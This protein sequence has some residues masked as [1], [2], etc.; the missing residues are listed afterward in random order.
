M[1]ECVK[2]GIGCSCISDP[3]MEEEICLCSDEYIARDGMCQSKACYDSLTDSFCSNYPGASCDN[4]N[5]KCMCNIDY[6]VSLNGRC[7]ADNCITEDPDTN[8]K[9]ECWGRGYCM[10]DYGG[11]NCVC[12]AAYVNRILCRFCNPDVAIE[13][14]TTGFL[15]ECVP[16]VCLDPK[17]PDVNIICNGYGT[18]EPHLQS[19][20]S[21]TYSCVCTEDS[22]SINNS[23]YPLECVSMALS[24]IGQYSVCNGYGTCNTATKACICNHPYTG[25]FCRSCLPG[26]ES[27]YTIT[28][29][30]IS[31]NCLPRTCFD[32]LTNSFCAGY[33]SCVLDSSTQTYKC[34]CNKDATF[35]SSFSMLCVPTQLLRQGVKRKL[36]LGLVILSILL[37]IAILGI[38]LYFL[39]KFLISKRKDK[40]RITYIKERKTEIARNLHKEAKQESEVLSSR[41]VL[42]TSDY[43]NFQ[44]RYM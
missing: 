40:Q 36:L 14:K 35:S 1:S 2:N 33:G 21:T 6:L 8:E 39:A 34:I 41:S 37:V 10:L 4:T 25:T 11:G 9:I 3:Q 27:Y 15:S 16:K 20:A 23:C 28:H 22:I 19:T 29:N 12:F 30:T 42:S 18:C 44:R 7:I 32:D 24:G 13:K 43:I 31:F 38:V 5:H 26:F 17:N